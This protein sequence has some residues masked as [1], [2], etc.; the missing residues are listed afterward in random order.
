MCSFVSVNT[1][2]AHSLNTVFKHGI[3]SACNPQDSV[4]ERGK[5]MTL[6]SIPGSGWAMKRRQARKMLG[7]ALCCAILLQPLAGYQALAAA[8]PVQPDEPSGTLLLPLTP[9]LDD[10]AMPAFDRTP[11]EPLAP[12]PA[13]APSDVPGEK[14]AP[15]HQIRA[16]TAE[17]KP[18]PEA[19][20]PEKGDFPNDAE[21]L[22]DDS[23]LHKGTV[24]IVADDTEFDQDNNTFLGTGNAVALIGG[25]D[26]KLEADTILYNQTT[27]IMDARGN[28]RML[29]N[30]QLT[31]G[32]AFKFKVSSDE[33]LITNPDTEVNGSQ[34]YARK[35]IGANKSTTFKDGT[36][37]MQQPFLISRNTMNGPLSYREGISEKQQHPD[38]F[39]PPKPSWTFKARKMVYEKYKDEGNLTI[40]G[41]KIMFGTF[42]VPLPPKFVCTIGGESKVMFPTSVYLG[43][44][45]MSGGTN[46]GPAFN[47]PIGK[48]G[49]LM[50]AP[51]IQVG[52]RFAATSNTSSTSNI[53]LAGQVAF[54][55][56][57]MGA[58]FGYGSVSNIPVGDIKV[59]LRKQL[60]V[61]VGLNRYLDDGMFGTR[62]AA[63]LIE[64]VDNHAFK[65][66]P[67]LS[68]INFRS[69]G[70]W[71]QDNPQLVQQF[72]QYAAL[73]GSAAN[74]TVE[75]Q[76][77]KVQEQITATT[78]PIFSVGNSKYGLKSYM[79]GGVAARGYSTGQASV[80]AQAGPVLDVYL[81]Q[82]RFQTGY[83]QS[84]VR[85]SSPFV[86]DQFI[87]GTQS[88]FL[89]GDVKVCKY[90]T[91]GGSL[92]YNMQ[93]K[94]FTTKAITAAIGPDDFKLLLFDNIVQGNYK[95]GFDVLY[96]QP[97]PFSKLVLKNA[98]DQG[99]IGGI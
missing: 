54:T 37:T 71:A 63:K 61:Q 62:R 79:Y 58:H 18:P 96:G 19:I 86:Y 2:P 39:V 97:I 11:P 57:F 99:Q 81:N 93:D 21:N 73:F 44:N 85:G 29:R 94:L 27:Q 82:V 91:V 98:P 51:L 8:K 35:A 87:Q 6:G 75:H 40:F 33:Y 67:F 28:V 36:M 26:S 48:T 5:L 88:V 9:K 30:G 95:V 7:V 52:G 53:G 89:A 17:L 12:E 50:W 65:N 14:S 46:F 74:S 66:V 25:E 13:D 77:F 59:R 49:V 1:K 64:L 20:T 92:G 80:I 23:K 55:N 72:S 69:S 16:T 60:K 15:T 34:I 47:T 70:G 84:A 41:G 45:L 32:S 68:S 24:S 31:A 10:G 56:Y 76:A 3:M 43:N 42:G 90:L 4:G 83:T 22:D 78:H 38:A